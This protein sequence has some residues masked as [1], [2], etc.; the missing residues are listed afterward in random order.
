M[1]VGA[2][3]PMLAAFMRIESDLSQDL[4]SNEPGTPRFRL[5]VRGSPASLAATLYAE[6]DGISLTAAV[7]NPLPKGGRPR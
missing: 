1:L 7:P 3:M 5:V 4:F 2:E 6:Y